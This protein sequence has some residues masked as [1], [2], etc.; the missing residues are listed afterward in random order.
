MVSGTVTCYIRNAVKCM[1]TTAI[2]NGTVIVDDCWRTDHI[3]DVTVGTYDVTDDGT[4]A[5][6]HSYRLS[7]DNH[8]RGLPALMPGSVLRDRDIPECYL[9]LLPDRSGLTVRKGATV[10]QKLPFSYLPYERVYA[11]KC[12]FPCPTRWT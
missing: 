7:S 11:P 12:V 8:E 5:R 6:G 9:K 1:L 4:D 10:R 3:P 2:E